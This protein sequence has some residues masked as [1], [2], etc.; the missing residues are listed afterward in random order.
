M[1]KIVPATA[2]DFAALTTLWEASVRATHH[3]LSEQHITTLRTQILDVYMPQL[4]LWS[5]INESGVAQG[6][7]G[8]H[9]NR[10]EMLFVSPQSRGTGVGKALLNYAISEL[11][12]NEVDVNEQ[13]PQGVGFYRHMGFVAVG[14]SELDGEGNPFPLLHLK[15]SQNDE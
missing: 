12:I 9:E 6:F 1:V 15:L 8:C 4:Q 14:R 10:V 11:A 3:F 2:D 5:A 13:N 7:I